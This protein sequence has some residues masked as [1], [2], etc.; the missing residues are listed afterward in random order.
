M[1]HLALRDTLIEIKELTTAMINNFEDIEKLKFLTQKLN[2]L[3]QIV[4]K[5]FDLN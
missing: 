4:I 5:V 2:L 1:N 3:N